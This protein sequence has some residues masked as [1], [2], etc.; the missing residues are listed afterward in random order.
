MSLKKDPLKFMGN[1]RD[2]I[3]LHIPEGVA[4]DSIT[5]EQIRRVQMFKLSFRLSVTT[6]EWWV[7][8]RKDGEG[9]KGRNLSTYRI[10]KEKNDAR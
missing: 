5:V 7:G 8:R 4:L 3:M 2:S 9:Q 10:W 1:I 6:P